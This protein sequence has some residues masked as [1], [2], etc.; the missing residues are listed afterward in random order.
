MD[1]TILFL[2]FS[3]PSLSQRLIHS[4]TLAWYC[5]L[6]ERF[7]SW[8]WF[9]FLFFFSKL[10]SAWESFLL[11]PSV[12]RYLQSFLNITL[13]W[14][15]SWVERKKKFLCFRQNLLPT[16]VKMNGDQVAEQFIIDLLQF[17]RSSKLYTDL[18]NAAQVLLNN[19][20]HCL[21]PM[22]MCVLL[23]VWIILRSCV[24][25][26]KSPNLMLTYCLACIQVNTR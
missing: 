20:K 8:N 26:L 3:N 4:S 14:Q 12:H 16:D 19:N 25:E 9:L 22:L 18:F 23:C 1:F 13:L 24:P 6:W 21:F 7:Q 2:S 10:V 11:L 17:L 15:C 5:W